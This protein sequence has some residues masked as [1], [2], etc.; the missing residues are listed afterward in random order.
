MAHSDL[1]SPLTEY[2]PNAVWLK[3]YPV[4]YSGLDFSARLTLL[5]LEDGSLVAHSPCPIDAT[6][7][8][9]LEALGELRHIVAP[10]NF[11][12]FYVGDWQRC[13]PQA[14]TWICPGVE[15]KRPDLHFDWLLGDRSPE[16]W[17]G[18]IDQALVR[19][20]RWI[21]EVAF[22]HRPSRVLILTDLVENVGDATPG[23]RG[24]MLKFWWKVVFRMWNRARPAPEYQ[25]GWYDKSAA[26]QSLERILAWDIDRVVIAHG[27]CIEE[28][29]KERLREAWARPLQG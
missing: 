21:W 11:H 14:T 1:E 8:H 12:Y 19:G 25:L 2:V 6:L 4:R 3:L 26:R 5:R 29:A 24:L 27:D 16:I 23:A 18:E 10:G 15:R 28:R 17:Q 9:Q 13:F 20:A 22:F 7:C